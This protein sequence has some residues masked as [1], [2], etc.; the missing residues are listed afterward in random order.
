MYSVKKTKQ[1]DITDK[2]KPELT[3]SDQAGDLPLKHITDEPL[4]PLKLTII[5][6]LMFVGVVVAGNGHFRKI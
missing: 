2:G 1:T 3:Q 5:S 6:Q 4:F